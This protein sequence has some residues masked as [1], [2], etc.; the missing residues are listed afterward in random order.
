MAPGL[1]C[2]VCTHPE[3]AA[4]DRALAAGHESERSAAKRWELSD[5]SVRRHKLKHIRSAVETAKRAARIE[6]AK[7]GAGTIDQVRELV[8]RLLALLE[9]AEGKAP[10]TVGGKAGKPGKPADEAPRVVDLKAAASLARAALSGL[11]VQAKILGEI[12]PPET[13][14]QLLVDQRGQPRPEWLAI[15]GAILAALRPYPEAADAVARALA[16]LGDGAPL[17]TAGA[18]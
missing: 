11:E 12:R 14:V 13:T 10:A 15:E 3:R 17:L 2:T 7:A 9:V 18:G 8:A 16:G 6:E 5:S 1:R 4:I